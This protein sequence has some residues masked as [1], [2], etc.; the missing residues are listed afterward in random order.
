METFPEKYSPKRKVSTV[1]TTDEFYKFVNVTIPKGSN[2]GSAKES[3]GKSQ[4]SSN[5]K[6]LL[7]FVLILVGVGAYFN[8]DKLPGWYS[9]FV[10]KLGAAT[11][12]TQARSNHKADGDGSSN[13]R[14]GSGED[15]SLLR[16][17]PSKKPKLVS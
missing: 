15:S 5:K 17:R 2:A 3:T 4:S 8:R 7:F 11:T 14:S 9:A 12:S 1:V 13:T 10:D 6:V 16:K